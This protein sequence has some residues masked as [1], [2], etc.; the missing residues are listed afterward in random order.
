M[1]TINEQYDLV[2]KRI[3]RGHVGPGGYQRS[4]LEGTFDV[5]LDT[6]EEMCDVF[7]RLNFL[8]DIPRSDLAVMRW[9]QA[10]QGLV[11]AGV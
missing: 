11:T 9:D 4:Y 3:C 1:T 8:A 7:N 6:L 2:W 10:Q 5:D